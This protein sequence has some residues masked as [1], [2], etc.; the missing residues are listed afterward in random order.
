MYGTDRLVATQLAYT[1]YD[2]I[3]EAMGGHGEH[4]EKPDDIRPAIE[5]ALASQKPACVN[6]VIKQDLEYKGGGYV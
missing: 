1:R 3:V 2:K 4:V 5:R 6:V